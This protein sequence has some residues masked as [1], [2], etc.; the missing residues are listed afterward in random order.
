MAKVNIYGALRKGFLYLVAIV[1]L[2]SWTIL[3]GAFQQP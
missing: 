3:V 2:F 1:D